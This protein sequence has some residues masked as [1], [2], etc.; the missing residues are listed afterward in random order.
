MAI[1]H[2]HSI[3]EFIETVKSWNLLF[4]QAR[5]RIRGSA[6]PEKRG[7]TFIMRPFTEIVITS[8]RRNEDAE[9]GYEIVRFSFDYIVGERQCRVHTGNAPEIR[10]L[11]MDDPPRFYRDRLQL[12]G[13]LVEQG[14][15]SEESLNLMPA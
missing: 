2:V 13:F 9:G 4:P 7:N 14:E 15:W 11:P 1:N 3:E 5:L 12:E 10:P 6:V 8:A